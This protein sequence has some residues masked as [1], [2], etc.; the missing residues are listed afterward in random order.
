MQCG[1][2]LYLERPVNFNRLKKKRKTYT[3]SGM[4]TQYVLIF[5]YNIFGTSFVLP[6]QV[7]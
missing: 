6:Q 3:K 2:K 5:P 7:R 4:D 1:A